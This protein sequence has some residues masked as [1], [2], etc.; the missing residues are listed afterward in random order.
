MR[1]RKRHTK[2]DCPQN[3]HWHWFVGTTRSERLII[4]VEYL[5]NA[6]PHQLVSYVVRWIELLT[7]ALTWPQ[8]SIMW[9]V[10]LSIYP[11]FDLAWPLVHPVH[12]RS[13]LFHEMTRRCLSFS[14]GKCQPEMV[15]LLIKMSG[16][17][18]KHV[19]I[20][21]TYSVVSRR[22]RLVKV[23]W[24]I[25]V[26]NLSHPWSW[27]G[28]RRMETNCSLEKLF[29]EFRWQFP[30]FLCRSHT[31]TLARFHGCTKLDMNEPLLRYEFRDN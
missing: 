16:A 24:H 7:C 22:T 10:G 25:E 28:R 27:S 20:S 15:S 26:G 30:S 13:L 4:L 23:G 2:V 11:H 21:P 12:L 14:P 31:W 5:F 3:A 8:A 6:R 17:T 18:L 9:S 19:Q 29:L 1:D